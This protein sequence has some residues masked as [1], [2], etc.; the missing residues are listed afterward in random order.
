MQTQIQH[1]IQDDYAADY[2]WCYGCGRLNEHDYHLRTGWEGDNTVTYYEPRKEH[3]AIP[4]FVYGGLIAS[5]IDCH[6]TGSAALALHRKNGHE[7]G[8]EDEQ[9]RFVTCS[10]KKD[11]LKS[12][13]EK[14]ILKAIGIVEE[15]QPNK[16]VV[17]KELYANDTLCAKGEVKA[18]VMPDT[19]MQ[20]K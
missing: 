13:A 10:L 16:W 9:T 1:A 15:I 11:F 14:A 18:A 2:A 4:G 6:G 7:P 8:D 5:I 20:K 3:T 19:F 17:H 12:R